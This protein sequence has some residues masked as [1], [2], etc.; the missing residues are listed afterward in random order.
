MKGNSAGFIWLKILRFPAKNADVDCWLLAEGK[1]G[2]ESSEV[3]QDLSLQF[4]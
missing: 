2:K 1:P 3:L 4:K